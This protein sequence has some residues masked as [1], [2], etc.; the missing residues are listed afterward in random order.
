MACVSAPAFEGGLVA[1]GPYSH[2]G[3]AFAAGL[4]CGLLERESGESRKIE[5]MERVISEQTGRIEE[6]EASEQMLR[7]ENMDLQKRQ[8]GLD[9]KEEALLKRIRVLDNKRRC[10]VLGEQ[11]VR[12]VIEHNAELQ[13]HLQK[14]LTNQHVLQAKIQELEAMQADAVS[15]AL[16]D[17]E[18]LR[19]WKR[20]KEYLS[21]CSVADWRAA[22]GKGV[23]KAHE[24]RFSSFAERLE[25]QRRRRNSDP[26]RPDEVF[27][28]REAKK[29]RM[30]AIDDW[31]REGMPPMTGLKRI[32]VHQELFGDLI[33]VIDVMGRWNLDVV[34][35]FRH[36]E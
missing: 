14:A 22:D 12:P 23:E 21:S 19:A 8:M 24:Q 11:E 1:F 6:L 15:A 25:V 10:K 34:T 7:K 13:R 3:Q 29:E 2:Y 17:V 5:E 4:H 30:C 35:V 28:K 26:P 20:S 32:R 16:E 27:D 36:P 33:E 9:K 31:Q 18:L